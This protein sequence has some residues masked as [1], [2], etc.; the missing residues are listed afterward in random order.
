M[1]RLDQKR[2]NRRKWLSWDWAEQ[3]ATL[4]RIHG[5]SGERVRQIRALLGRPRARDHKKMKCGF[6]K[7]VM[8]D[9]LKQFPIVGG[10]VD[11]HGAAKHFGCTLSTVYRLIRDHGRVI[12][13]ARSK[14][15]WEGLNWRETNRKIGAERG[16]PPEAVACHRH[17]YRKGPPDERFGSWN[18]VGHR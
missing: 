18:S 7:V 11:P 1:K 15:N 4:A 17:R 13:S 6:S 5:V 9:F 16:I 14:Y 2:K 3:N 8:K 10:E 12:K